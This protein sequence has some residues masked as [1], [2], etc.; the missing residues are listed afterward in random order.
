MRGRQRHTTGVVPRANARGIA[1]ITAMLVV[2]L[3]SIVAAAVLV[4]AN[5]AIRRAATLIDGERSWWYA[6]G[7]ESFARRILARDLEKN[8]G[9]DSLDED[10]ARSLDYLPVE[11]GALRGKLEDLQGRFN[12]NNLAAAQPLKY[13]QQLVRLFQSIEGMDVAQAQPLAEAIRDW[14]D[15]NQI[16]GGT[17]GAEDTDYLSLPLPYRTANQPMSSPSE[18]LAIKGVTPELYRRLAPYICT[19]P[20][21]SNRTPTK[22]NV[23]TAL[24]PVLMSLSATADRGKLDEFMIDR[25]KNPAKT[26][27]ELQTKGTLPADVAADMVDVKSQFF[28]MSTEA[29]IGSGRAALYSVFQR[30][31][32]GAPKVIARSLDTE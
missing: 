24:Q 13:Q 6:Q 15:D 1:L 9:V 30:A 5:N 31:G 26:V 21:G 22:I 7:L 12:L 10:W 23:N 2:A 29:F 27:Q 17:G 14:I 16:P 19:L 3:A 8:G 25:L 28:L 32:S 20:I 4:S 18:L 11:Q